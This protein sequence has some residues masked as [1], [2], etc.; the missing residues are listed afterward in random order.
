MFLNILDGVNL[1]SWE[2]AVDY[3]PGLCIS[4]LP[5]VDIQIMIW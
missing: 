1:Q 2:N 5:I 3:M 4:G